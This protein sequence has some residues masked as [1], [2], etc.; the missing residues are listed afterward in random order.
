MPQRW[1]TLGARPAGQDWPLAWRDCPDQELD[2]VHQR[3]V[4]PWG[5]D[6]RWYEH[7]KRDLLLA[8]LPR[9]RF[10]HALEVGCSTG[11]LTEA[12]TARADTVLGVDQSPTAL[13]AARR[14]LG[15]RP[16]VTVTAVD[17]SRDWPDGT[18]DLV[19]VSEVGYFLSPAAL[20]RL[21]SHVAGCLTPDGVVVLCHWRHRVEGWVMDADEVHRRFEAGPV[22][23]VQARYADRDVELR[24]HAATWP[25]YDR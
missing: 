21:V 24:V 3:S 23:P 12:L 22:P 8:A 14:R 6:S 19:V 13:D 2:R 11:A 5:V 16:A 1:G 20:D 17:V 7:R 18:F 10:R 15:E 9:A 4:D 25:P